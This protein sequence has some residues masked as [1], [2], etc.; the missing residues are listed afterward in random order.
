MNEEE[1]KIL[2]DSWIPSYKGIKYHQKGTANSL[3]TVNIDHYVHSHPLQEEQ[4]RNCRDIRYKM[5]YKPANKSYSEAKNNTNPKKYE[6]VNFLEKI[7]LEDPNILTELEFNH[8]I[9]LFD[10]EA[11]QKY[12]SLAEKR[13]VGINDLKLLWLSGFPWP[14]YEVIKTE[15]TSRTLR[16][17]ELQAESKL[18]FIPKTSEEIRKWLLNEADIL[19]SRVRRRFTENI[20]QIITFIESLPRELRQEVFPDLKQRFRNESMLIF[21]DIKLDQIVYALKRKWQK[22]DDN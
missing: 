8:L 3:S 22:P 17:E 5:D 18:Q 1:F 21:N 16:K 20:S 10:D 6:L 11:Y 15:I 13:S 7:R 4:G 9:E 12:K 19:D 14:E 2:I